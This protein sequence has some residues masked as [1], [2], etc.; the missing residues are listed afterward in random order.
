VHRGHNK[1]D[2][3][4]RPAD[5]E[6]YLS[7]LQEFRQ[8]Y[9]VKL[10]AYCLMTNHV[11]LLL[12]P[13]SET[14][15]A[16]LMKRVA[17]RYTRYYNRRAARS[18]TL[19]EGRY[20]S[21]L[22]ERDRYLLACCRYIE[23]NPVR[24]GL[25]VDPRQYAWSS[26]AHRFSGDAEGWIDPDPCYTA[27]GSTPE[28]RRATYAA[29][30]ETGVPEEQRKFIRESLQRGHPTS[31]PRHTGEIAELVGRSIVRRAP[32]RPRKINLS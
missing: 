1:Q 25:V 29:Y 11:H 17:G 4:H 23:L 12:A 16:Q 28:E 10:Y 6:R 14:G 20:R 24:A 32:G 30:L 7:T 22:V 27:M 31:G 19:W 13:A 15:I 26:C 9:A 3:F 21:S 8:K 5:Y 18:G 2:V